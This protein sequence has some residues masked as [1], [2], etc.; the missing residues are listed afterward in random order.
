MTASATVPA[1]IVAYAGDPRGTLVGFLAGTG[2]YAEAV[3][4]GERTARG[5]APGVEV[6]HGLGIAY[7]GLGQT[8]RGGDAHSRGHGKG[9]TRSGNTSAPVR[10]RW[11]NYAG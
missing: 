10:A 6:S 5:A 1:D 7:A 3:R 9:I 2:H 11:T 8:G 4:V